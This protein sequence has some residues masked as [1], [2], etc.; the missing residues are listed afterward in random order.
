M[1][2]KGGRVCPKCGMNLGQKHLCP[3]C[4][5][6]EQEH[7]PMSG[8]TS[9]SQIAGYFPQI[10]DFIGD[11]LEDWDNEF[12]AFFDGLAGNHDFEEC[13][14]IC[15]KVSAILG[16]N[17][18]VSVISGGMTISVMRELKSVFPTLTNEEARNLAKDL[19]QK[20]VDSFYAPP[21]FG[22]DSE[23]VELYRKAM[24]QT[25][26]FAQRMLGDCYHDG[27][28][29]KVNYDEAI[30]WYRKAAEQGD[31]EAQYKL[32]SCYDNG[33]GVDVNYDEAVKWYR[34]AAKQ[35]NAKAQLFLGGCYFS[36]EGVKQNNNEAFKWVRKAAEQGNAVA[37]YNMGYCYENGTGVSEN[38]EEAIKWYRMAAEQ[39]EEDAKIKL[40]EFEP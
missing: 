13:Y 27:K 22:S 17:K 38:I 15:S 3:I 6:P 37:Q 14:N 5:N 23:V 7:N 19:L 18:P 39:G 34:K 29:V 40:K 20:R 30:K 10:I 36:G 21:P 32:G 8:N 11:H 35:G 24:E 28:G 31:A 4:D 25:N 2:N 12:N 16:K 33:D 9:S 26:T 1:A